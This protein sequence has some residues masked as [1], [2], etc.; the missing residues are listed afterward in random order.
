MGCAA[1]A[2]S[3]Q[4]KKKE[5]NTCNIIKYRQTFFIFSIRREIRNKNETL[6][7]VCRKN[8]KWASRG[9]EEEKDTRSDFFANEKDAH[10]KPLG[11]TTRRRKPSVLRVF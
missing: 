4:H 5:L 10:T 7:A 1:L 8:K 9:Q 11:Y 6:A 3:P 2:W